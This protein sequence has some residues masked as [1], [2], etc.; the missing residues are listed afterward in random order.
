MFIEFKF[1]NL[2]RTKVYCEIT[3]ISL[4]V[5]WM[6]VC[7]FDF[8]KKNILRKRWNDLFW[9]LFITVK[10]ETN[11][12][13]HLNYMYSR[14][15]TQ[16]YQ[17]NKQIRWKKNNNNNIVQVPRQ[18]LITLLSVL[19]TISVCLRSI[20]NSKPIYWKIF[21]QMKKKKEKKKQSHYTDFLIERNKQV[22]WAQNMKSIQTK[23]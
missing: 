15:P 13:L 5:Q 23:L 8:I 2:F 6:C 3:I 4:F 21:S 7:V 11:F 12:S 1:S 9:C 14:R 19:F 20:W 10:Y 18:N 16:Y 17:I 22:R